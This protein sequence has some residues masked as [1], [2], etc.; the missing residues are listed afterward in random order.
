MLLEPGFALQ[1][2]WADGIR[3]RHQAM[4]AT[5]WRDVMSIAFY[6]M[7][8]DF[9]QG[10]AAA[11]GNRFLLQ[12]VQ[13]QNRLRRVSNYEFGF[14]G[15]P[16]RMTARVVANC[17]DHLRILDAVEA[18]TM[19]VAAALMRLHLQQAQLLR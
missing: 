8:A 12:A 16:A 4:L 6:E 1:P 11:C 14:A 2:G 17:T 15:D 10:L 5:P 13:Q 19:E 9:H 3:A 7:N 18:G